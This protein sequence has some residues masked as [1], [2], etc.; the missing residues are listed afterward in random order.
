MRDIGDVPAIFFAVRDIDV[1]VLHGSPAMVRLLR[2]TNLSVIA[3][4][5][6]K[7]ERHQE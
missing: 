5:V 1:V 7:T 3:N 2:F 6:T 4:R